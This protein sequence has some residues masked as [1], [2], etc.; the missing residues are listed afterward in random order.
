MAIHASIDGGDTGCGDRLA[1][2][3]TRDF[4]HE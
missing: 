4:A 2:V 3:K 1:Q